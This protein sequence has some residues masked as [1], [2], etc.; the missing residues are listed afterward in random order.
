MTEKEH[1]ILKAIRN[2]IKETR[3]K[4]GLSIRALAAK[5]DLDPTLLHEYEIGIRDTRSLNLI[6]ILVA[7][8]IDLSSLTD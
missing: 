6:R 8:D 2:K 4:Q 7:L 1:I 3:T 5:A